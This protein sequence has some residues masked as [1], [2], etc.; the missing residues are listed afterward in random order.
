MLEQSCSIVWWCYICNKVYLFIHREEEYCDKRVCLSVCNRP[1]ES[2][3]YTSPDF[4][5]M[6][7]TLCTS[8]L[9]A[10][11]LRMV[12]F[13]FLPIMSRMSQKTILTMTYQRVTPD[14]GGVWYLRLPCLRFLI[15]R[16]V[17]I[18]YR[19]LQFFFSKQPLFKYNIS[20]SSL[21]FVNK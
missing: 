13:L 7:H 3:I 1:Q 20:T 21:P 2:H 9:Y 18:I 12:L 4:L 17:D 19:K 16:R 11:Y 15:C 5:C 8:G 10:M 14:R 6:L